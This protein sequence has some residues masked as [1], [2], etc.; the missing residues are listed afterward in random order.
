M[1]NVSELAPCFILGAARSGTKLL[2]DLLGHS[3]E[4][5]IVP[6]DVGYIWRWGNEFFPSDEFLPEMASKKIK[7]HIRSAL[8]KL[9]SRDTGTQAKI[10]LE[11]SVPNTLR[12]GFLA[13]IYPEARFIHLV[14]D[15]RA[16]VESSCRQ[17]QAP[18]DT[19]YLIKKLKYFPWSNYRYAFWYLSNRIKGRLSTGR[20]QHIWGPRYAGIDEDLESCSL[21]TVCAR[22]WR[23]CVESSQLQTGRLDAGRVL[24]IRYEDLVKNIDSLQDVCRFLDVIPNDQLMAAYRQ[25]V[26]AENLEKWRDRIKDFDFNA[27]MQEIQPLQEKLG[28]Q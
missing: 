2:R 17:W 11:K 8:P 23:C 20:G 26:T 6:Y 27:V 3:S 13:E 21:E 16:V 14:R 12:A 5:A 9:V 19:G 15:G 24:E 28:Y 1:S 4:I 10:L 25:Q 22:Q 18:P 7:K